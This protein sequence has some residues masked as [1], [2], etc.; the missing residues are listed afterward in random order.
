MKA[1]A[2]LT[3]K[4]GT[5][6]DAMPF[7]FNDYATSRKIVREVK[8]HWGFNAIKSKSEQS[9]S[10]IRVTLHGVKCNIVIYLESVEVEG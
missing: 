3:D 1:I 9:G 7:D 8:S 2:H 10:T 4:K 5:V 6:I